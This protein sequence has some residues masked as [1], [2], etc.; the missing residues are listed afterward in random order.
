MEI[1]SFLELIFNEY[2]YVISYLIGGINVILELSWL[3]NRANTYMRNTEQLFRPYWVLSAVHI[4][5][6]TSG[7]RTNNHSMEKPKIYHGPPAHVTYKRCRIN[8]SWWQCA[9]TW[10]NVS[11]RYVFPTEDTATS[12]ATSSQVVVMNRHNVNLMGRKYCGCWFDLQGWRLRCALLT[13]PNE[14]ETAVQCSVCR[15]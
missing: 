2:I 5:I 3:E 13:R 4:V 12:G 8:Y 9:N 6:S 10:P 14:V 15:M 1:H 11:W 7:D